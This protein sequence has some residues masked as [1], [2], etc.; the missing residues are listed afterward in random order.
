[1]SIWNAFGALGAALYLGSY[2]LL[3]L[4]LISGR[5]VIYALMNAAAAGS[6]LLSLVDAW[7]GSVALMQGTWVVLSVVGLTRLYLRARKLRFTDEESDF[8]SRRFSHLGKLDARHLLDHGTWSDVPPDVDLT[9]EGQ[10]VS[11]LRY[12]A[13]GSALVLS[14]GQRV[15]TLD[16]GAFIGEITCL[17]GEPATGTVRTES[18]CRVLSFEAQGLRK[19][20]QKDDVIRVAV[21]RT[22]AGTIKQ[23]LILATALLS[24]GAS[25]E[26]SAAA[27]QDA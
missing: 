13:S 4:G 21:E 20:C 25:S 6:V 19:L 11:H 15:N 23:K 18:P 10:S 8:I 27:Q 3:Q 14:N 2:F 5:G 9:T 26:E 1:V 17:T 12:I 16:D 22:L 24:E 7:N